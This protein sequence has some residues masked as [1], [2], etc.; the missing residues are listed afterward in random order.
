MVQIRSRSRRG[1]T[2][3]EFALVFPIYLA[4]ISS[5]VLVGIRIF[6]NH[7]F[8][9]MAKF[10]ARKAI[11]HGASAEKLGT[12]GPDPLHGS[13]GDG[14]TIGTMLAAK[15]TD[16]QPAN[17]FYRLTWPDNGND[18]SRGD[19]VMVT[20]ASFDLSSDLAFDTEAPNLNESGLY[21]SSASVTLTIM[22]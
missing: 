16:G 8:T 10:L 13:L 19:R 12:W 5:T 20:I 21:R 7:Q 14:T 11:V 18:A 17:I 4:V 9:T 3:L 2:I 1:A 15:F 22:H 6:Q